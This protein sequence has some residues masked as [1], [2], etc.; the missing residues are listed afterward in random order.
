VTIVARVSHKRALDVAAQSMADILRHDE[1]SRQ[2]AR[3]AI[4]RYNDH[5]KTCNRVIEAKQEGHIKS[6]SATEAELQRVTQELADTR[7]ENRALRSELAKKS[8]T[9][10]ATTPGPTVDY[11]AVRQTLLSWASRYD[12]RMVAYDPWNATDLVPMG[13]KDRWNSLP[14]TKDDEFAKYV[15]HP[16]LAALLPILYPGVFPNL[17]SYTKVRADLHA[18]LLTG[19]PAG[20]VGGFQPDLLARSFAGD[21]SGILS[22]ALDGLGRP[23]RRN[24]DG[25][26]AP[27]EGPVAGDFDF[28]NI[29]RAVELRR[30]AARLRL[31]CRS[32]LALP[33][34]GPSG[35]EKNG[36]IRH[37]TGHTLGFPHEHMRKDLVAK[38]DPDKAIAFFS[39]TQ[40]WSAEETMGSPMRRG[41]CFARTTSRVM[42][43]RRKPTRMCRCW[44]RV[45]RHWR[46]KS[47]GATIRSS[48][49]HQGIAPCPLR[50][51]ISRKP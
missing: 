3:E 22:S 21:A 4:R 11:D 33:H 6:T 25:E 44:G 40:G 24:G 7:E 43:R 49:N 8:R 20:V 15:D 9:G 28:L 26:L 38:I 31:E 17:Q 18:I 48:P 1:Y 13:D 46:R 30:S 19:I 36:V 47:F 34:G 50:S 2:A 12:L 37:E 10:A 5:I 45:P 29:A 42:R 32:E 14:P 35:N 51:G 23:W 39:E 16:E 41:R 27:H